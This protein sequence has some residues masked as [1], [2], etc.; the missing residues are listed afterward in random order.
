MSDKVLEP[1]ATQT[2]VAVSSAP[3]NK[4]PEHRRLMGFN[5]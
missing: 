2:D 4:N 3:R 5:N 1:E